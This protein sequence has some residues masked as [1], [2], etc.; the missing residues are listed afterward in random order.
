MMKTEN[1]STPDLLALMPCGLRN[2]FK[3]HID[4]FME[5]HPEWFEGLNYIVEGNVN[6]ETRYYPE[7]DR[8]QSVDDLPDIVISSDVNAF[9]HKRFMDRFS[10]QF[11]TFMPYL[12]H[13]YLADAGFCDPDGHFSM[14]TANLLI[15]AVDKSKLGNRPVPSSWADLLHPDFANDIILR[16]EDDFFCNAVLLPYY[17]DYGMDAIRK[18]ARNVKSGHHPAEMVKLAGSD[19]EEAAAVYVL[20]YFFAAK[21][22]NPQ[23]EVIWPKEGAILSPVFLLVK[24]TS[25]E[26]NRRI[27]DFIFSK[28]TAELFVR[29]LAPSIHPEM[30]SEFF[31]GSMKFLGWEFLKQNDIGLL[32]DQIQKEFMA[33]WNGGNNKQFSK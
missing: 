2:P 23:V 7:I 32:K 21:I 22:R 33:I 10:S 4:S 18:L 19:K 24:K 11:V 8:L 6:H 31:S 30:S 13:P 1:E 3:T 27:L 25:L 16:G 20:P 12:P 17:K 29:N 14:L 9:F 5:A 15:M 28:E 26:K